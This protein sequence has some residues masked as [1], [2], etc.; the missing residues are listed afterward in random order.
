MGSA[1]D[2]AAKNP[3]KFGDVCPKLGDQ[4]RSALD[5]PINTILQIK[6]ASEINSVEISDDHVEEGQKVEFSDKDDVHV[7]PFRCYICKQFFGAVH[8]FY[9]QVSRREKRIAVKKD[10]E[11]EKKRRNPT[12]VSNMRRG[13]LG[14][15]KPNM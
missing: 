10:K 11:T 9:D 7:F 15:E 1:F 5:T 14:E 6:A 12:V 13:E 4:I 3:E 8:H 2:T